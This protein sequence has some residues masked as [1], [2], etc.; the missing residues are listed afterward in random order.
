VQR[1]VDAG[2]DARTGREWPIDDDHAV[3]DH[4]RLRRQRS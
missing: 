4:L 2:R 3:V 1:D